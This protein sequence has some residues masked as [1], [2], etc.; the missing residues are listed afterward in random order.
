M[1]TAALPFLFVSSNFFL[2][3][4]F[5]NGIGISLFSRSEVPDVGEAPDWE[6]RRLIDFADAAVPEL[7]HPSG[8]FLEII[9]CRGIHSLESNSPGNRVGNQVC[10]LDACRQ[11]TVDEQRFWQN[12]AGPLTT[13]RCELEVPIHLFNQEVA[14]DFLKFIE[15]NNSVCR[16][17]N[18]F[19]VVVE[20]LEQIRIILA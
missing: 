18:V 6:V 16:G 8:Q 5:F 14:L 11:V 13:P 12:L 1:A 19:E 10:E 20:A 15:H 7:R 4:Q 3:Q 17:S 9:S 2:P